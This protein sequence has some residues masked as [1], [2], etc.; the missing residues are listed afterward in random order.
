MRIDHSAGVSAK[1]EIRKHARE[2]NPI[3]EGWAL[4]PDGNPTTHPE[5]GL[6][7]SMAPACGYKGA[8]L[9]LIVETMAAAMTSATLGLD[10]SPFSETK[11]GPPTTWQMFL[12]IDPGRTSGGAFAAPMSALAAAVREREGPAFP[13]TAGRRH[14]GW[15]SRGAS[16]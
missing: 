14:G 3:P 10:A 11:G 5:A 6:A 9:A 4:D 12:A 8:R 7:G 15:P 1:S 13:A 2:G 16:R